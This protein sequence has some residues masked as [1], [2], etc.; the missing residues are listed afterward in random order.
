MIADKKAMD[1]IGRDNKP[2][3]TPMWRLMVDPYIAIIAGA[4]VAFGEHKSFGA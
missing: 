2:T 4:L 3:G 1:D